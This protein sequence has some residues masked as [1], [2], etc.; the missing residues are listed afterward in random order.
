MLTAPRV[1]GAVVAVTALAVA[2]CSTAAPGSQPSGGDSK[3]AVVAAE[4]FWGSIASQLGGSHVTETSII[5]SPSTDPHDYEPTAANARTIALA[6]LVIVNGIGYDPW[7]PKLISA[8]PV[9]GRTELT[10]GTLLGLKDSDNPHQWYSAASVRRVITA[11]TAGYRRLDPADA[12][13][14]TRRQHWF[15]TTALARYNNVIAQIKSRYAGTPVGA[16]ESIVSP[17]AATLGLKML[18]PPE[19]LRG[20]SA[21][22]EPTAQ[23][24]TAID[25][26]IASRRIKVYI[27]NSQNA[28]PDVA[29]Q[30]KA[31]RAHHIPVT[32]VTETLAPASAT[33]EQWQVSQLQR[34]AAAL[35]QATGR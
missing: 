35:H 28:T 16:S 31:A 10:V 18:T 3:I 4:N 6:K 9:A 12:G 22:S 29:A 13:Y 24:K 5:T 33:F 8:N 30:V 11:I 20:I 14:F 34:L 21:G 25:R 1:A 32:A 19:F 26:Q 7:A 15:E 23:D 27:Y 17:L 2:G